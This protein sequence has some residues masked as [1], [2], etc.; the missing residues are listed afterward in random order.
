MALVQER[1]KKLWEQSLRQSVRKKKRKKHGWQSSD[2]EDGGVK[3]VSSSDSDSSQQ[4]LDLLESEPESR[5]RKG[6][7]GQSSS[8]GQ[9]R[10]KLVVERVLSRR[11]MTHHEWAH[12]CSAMRTA[13]IAAG[14]RLKV[15]LKAALNSGGAQQHPP[16]QQQRYL[17]KWADLSHL[18]VS[19]ER[20]DDMLQAADADRWRRMRTRFDN[21]QQGG[22]PDD[23]GSS[24]FPGG[25]DSG[26]CLV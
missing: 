19:W 12:F 10:R 13:E 22:A 21:Q 16:P 23:A 7:G 24:S 8:A 15:A 14:S 4:D 26:K 9:R 20:H 2:S 6:A 11:S 3:A 1:R 5:G 17:V 25:G 18:H